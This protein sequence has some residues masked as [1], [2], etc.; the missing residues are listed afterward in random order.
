MSALIE[1]NNCIQNRAGIA[2]LHTQS[3]IIQRNNCSF[4]SWGLF[5]EYSSKTFVSDNIFVGPG[6]EGVSDSYNGKGSFLALCE[7]VTFVNN[8]ITDF[9]GYGIEVKNSRY[10]NFTFNNIYQ[11]SVKTNVFSIYIYETT[12]TTFSYNL[13]SQN[14]Y[15]GLGIVNSFNNTI[16]HNAFIENGDGVEDHAEEISSNYNVWYDTTLSEGNFWDGWDFMIPYSIPG[17]NSTDPYPLE[18]NPL[19]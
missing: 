9:E 16:H 17:G 6:M 11:N 19:S 1:E 4:N 13:V 8:L 3:V 15:I 14:D 10:C 7:N 18:Q 5:D 2:L 12:S